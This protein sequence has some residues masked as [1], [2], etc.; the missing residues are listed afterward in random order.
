M[1]KD[2]E[3][4]IKIVEQSSFNAFSKENLWEIWSDCVIFGHFYL[5]Q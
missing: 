5:L 3:N 1:L 2:M 4:K